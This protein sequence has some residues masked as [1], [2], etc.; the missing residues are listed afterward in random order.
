MDQ[1][2]L[3]SGLPGGAGF[4]PSDEMRVKFTPAG[5]LLS[6]ELAVD[7]EKFAADPDTASTKV[8]ALANDVF[9][10][11]EE[12]GPPNAGLFTYRVPQESMK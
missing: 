9:P 12:E 8:R 5:G 4:W 3:V 2:L 11:C 1:R 7:P 6:I 10:G